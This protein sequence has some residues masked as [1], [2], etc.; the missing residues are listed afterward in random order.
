MLEAGLVKEDQFLVQNGNINILPIDTM[1]S[2]IL[3]NQCMVPCSFPSTE[4]FKS[5]IFYFYFFKSLRSNLGI[6]IVLYQLWRDNENGSQDINLKFSW[7]P[8][9]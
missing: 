2:R 6:L 3:Y 5:S 1:N 4:C 9:T 7:G 8:Y